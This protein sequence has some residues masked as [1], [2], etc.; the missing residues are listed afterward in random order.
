[1]HLLENIPGRAQDIFATSENVPNPL[2][3]PPS[4]IPAP[5]VQ[6]EGLSIQESAHKHAPWLLGGM[7]LVGLDSYFPQLSA[8]S[9]L[10]TPLQAAIPIL[11]WMV[12]LC[13]LPP[14]WEPN[15]VSLS[16]LSHT[17]EQNNCDALL[18]KLSQ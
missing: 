13:I 9:S 3:S 12:S 16:P 5:L 10:W 7:I 14:G 6:E 1:M 15:L 8:M 11:H 18:D 17:Q 2:P 4:E